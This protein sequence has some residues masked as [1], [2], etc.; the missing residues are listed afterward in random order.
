[1]QE[2]VL[3]PPKV[4]IRNALESAK[5]LSDAS[6][7]EDTDLRINANVG[8]IYQMHTEWSLARTGWGP[9]PAW[10]DDHAY[11]DRVASTL[12]DLGFE[13]PLERIFDRE[14]IEGSTLSESER[15]TYQKLIQLAQRRGP[16]AAAAMEGA[17]LQEGHGVPAIAALALVVV[18]AVSLWVVVI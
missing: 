5:F 1:M 17:M 4:S 7:A 18:V 10:L 11:R 15:D 16:A 13:V 6:L 8:K 2:I 9:N 3:Q 14:R 12:K